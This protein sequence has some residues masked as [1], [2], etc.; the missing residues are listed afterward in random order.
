MT[1]LHDKRREHCGALSYDLGVDVEWCSICGAIRVNQEGWISPKAYDRMLPIYMKQLAADRH[2]REVEDAG[3]SF[4]NPQHKLHREQRHPAYEYVTTENARKSG[5]APVPEGEGWEPND[6]VP[7]DL[8]KD[9]VMIEKRWRSW[10]RGDLTEINYWRR[11]RASPRS[12]EQI[13]AIQ[14]K[15]LPQIRE[16]FGGR[17]VVWR[18]PSMLEVFNADARDQLDLLRAF[19]SLREPIE[20]DLV[21]V[22]CVLFHTREE[23]AR[24]YPAMMAETKLPKGDT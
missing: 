12:V 6:I 1:E 21:G 14:E 10:S 18:D 9:G 2:Q 20:A 8:Y 13:F 23:T 11:P 15:W 16:A 3:L 22:I 19:R 24:L 4:E 7:C 5:G 17:P